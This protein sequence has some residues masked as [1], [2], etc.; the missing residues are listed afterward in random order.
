MLNW[1]NEYHHVFF[2]TFVLFYCMCLF[3]HFDLVTPNFAPDVKVLVKVLFDLEVQFFSMLICRICIPLFF[4][5]SYNLEY[6]IPLSCTDQKIHARV[7]QKIHVLVKR[8]TKIQ[9]TH[10]LIITN[11]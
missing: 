7:G 10:V 4:S 5:C 8:S 9:N 3:D 11:S 1:M 2:F 6:P